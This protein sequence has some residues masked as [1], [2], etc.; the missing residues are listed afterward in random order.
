MR[1][2]ADLGSLGCS[3]S[4]RRLDVTF[5]LLMEHFGLVSASVWGFSREEIERSRRYHRPLYALRGVDIALGILVPGVLAF[6]HAAS[7]F[8]SWPWWLAVLALAALVLGIQAVLGFPGSLWRYRREREWGFSTQKVGSWLG[9]LGKGLGIGAA[10]SGAAFLA[11]IASARLFSTWWPLVA[12]IGA[13]LLVLL[14]GFVAPVVLEPVFNKFSPLPDQEL[15]DDLRALSVE[16]GVPV[17]DVLVADA[18][19]RTNKQNAYV[20]GL[21][22][23]RRVVIWDTLLGEAEPPELRLVV[24]HELAHRRLRHVA[25]GTVA[26]MAGIAGFVVVLWA[27]L[28]WEALR[29]A[30]GVDGP[31]DPG[32]VLF[33]FFI[34]GVLELFALPL[35]T[36]LSRRFEREADRYSLDLTSD[37][38]AYESVHHGLATA[39]LTDLEPPRLYYLL[40]H[41]HP[42]APE[43]IAAGRAWSA[44]RAAAPVA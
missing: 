21:G 19:R 1:D 28:R 39:N 35:L 36:G 26:A 3:P 12:A 41:G 37:P 10:L 29:D 16:A 34:G 23:T 6:A 44:E 7:I 43:R 2:S 27:L 42:T 9:D 20:S 18:S 17:R 24:A 11:L 31:G 25:W 33:A 14:L 40:F 30:I 8:D 5:R 32:V 13:A 22:T 38:D 4:L 15:A